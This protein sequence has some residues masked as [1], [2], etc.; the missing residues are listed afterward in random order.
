MN[1]QNEF[2][3]NLMKRYHEK[4]FHSM[5]YLRLTAE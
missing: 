5:I 4:Q 1:I 3:N 2:K